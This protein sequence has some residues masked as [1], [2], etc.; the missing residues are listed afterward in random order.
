MSSP[1]EDRISG[2]Q[3]FNIFALAGFLLGIVSVVS[4]VDYLFWLIPA[5]GALLSLY[6]L[7]RIALGDKEQVG[8]SLAVVGLC[9]SLFFLVAAPLAKLVEWRYIGAESRAFAEQ[10]FHYLGQ[11]DAVAAYDMTLSY[12][13]R[14][15]REDVS[16]R[17][18]HLENGLMWDYFYRNLW[19]KKLFDQ[20][21]EFTAE[22]VDTPV[23]EFFNGRYRVRHRYRIRMSSQDEFEMFDLVLERNKDFAT[24][25]WYWQIESLL[26][27][28]ELP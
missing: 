26:R 5:A 13:T 25:K 2:Y 19:P 21:T 10:W 1:A 9:R 22:Y 6:A 24:G 14:A 27:E 23:Q 17:A 12:P 15:F 16:D 11:G 7:W 4:L 20:G 8:R 28:D 18:M 3:T